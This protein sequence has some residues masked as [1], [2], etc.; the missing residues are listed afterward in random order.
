MK[1]VVAVA[2]SFVLVLAVGSQVF[3]LSEDLREARI[4]FRKDFDKQTVERVE[5]VLKHKDF[6]FQGGLV[7]YWEPHFGTTLVYNGDS[8]SLNAFVGELSRVPGMRVKVSF[9]K[10]LSKETRGFPKAGSWWVK[11]SHLTPDVL[12][13]RVNLAASELDPEQLEFWSTL[14]GVETRTRD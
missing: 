1:R 11:Y 3:G 9:S 7:S 12:T 6:K 5:R 2:V 13:V 10:D 8:K 14:S 4:F